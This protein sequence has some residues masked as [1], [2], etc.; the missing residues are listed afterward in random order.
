MLGVGSLKARSSEHWACFFD[1]TGEGLRLLQLPDMNIAIGNLIATSFTRVHTA[2]TG[3]WRDSQNLP[4]PT[5]WTSLRKALGEK[6]GGGA[7]RRYIR[8][9]NVEIHFAK[10]TCPTVCHGA[11]SLASRRRH[12]GPV[13]IGRSG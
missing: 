11:N 2:S 10:A 6:G 9:T 7:R 13:G 1:A 8:L 4:T 3:I 5:G 12:A